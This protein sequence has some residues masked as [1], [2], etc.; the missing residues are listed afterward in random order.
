[1]RAARNDRIHQITLAEG[2]IAGTQQL[3]LQARELRQPKRKAGIVAE[4]PEITEMIG[5][6][7]EL[8][9]ERAQP[10]S[11]WRDLDPGDALERLAIGPGEGYR[12]I[13]RHAR[14][15]A[16]GVEDVELREAPLDALVDVAE[17]LFEPQHF[18]ADDGEAKVP[19]LD[20]ARV[21][22]ADRNLVHTLAV[23][24]HERVHVHA[25]LVIRQLRAGI[26]E[27]MH[28]R[29]PGVVTQP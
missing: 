22:R 2:L 27:R 12:G 17:P 28:I 6:A 13:A 23:D 18:L 9:I 29:R 19:G 20:D 7:L 8:E 16:M 3:F 26:D 4:R 24:A 15:E 25:T 1:M 5:N 10:R 14:R 11:P 21:H